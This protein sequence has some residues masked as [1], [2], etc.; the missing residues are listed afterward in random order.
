MPMELPAPPP[1]IARTNR[2]VVFLV[3]LFD[4]AVLLSGWI[5]AQVTSSIGWGFVTIVV[6]LIIG[7]PILLLLVRRIQ[8]RARAAPVSDSNPR[9]DQP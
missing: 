5:V 4:V 9:D 6:A 7:V 3:V 8:G 2:I 1:E